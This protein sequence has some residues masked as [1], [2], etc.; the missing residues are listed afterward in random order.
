MAA[1]LAALLAGCGEDEREARERRAEELGDSDTDT[2]VT[3]ERRG[4][5]MERDRQG[6]PSDASGAHA[7]RGRAG[8][9]QPGRYSLAIPTGDEQTSALLVEKNMPERVVVGEV[10]DYTIEVTNLTDQPLANV[11]VIETAGQGLAF[12]SAEQAG[13]AGSAPG[14]TPPVQRPTPPGQQ[15]GQSPAQPGQSFGQPPAQF[16]SR[17]ES[18]Y[19]QRWEISQLEPGQTATIRVWAVPRQL[20]ETTT[21]LTAGYE[22]TIVARLQVLAPGQELVQDPQGQQQQPPVVRRN[23]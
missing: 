7:R 1:L 10:T 4:Y 15:P 18:P 14:R 5:G 2:L 11:W 17:M 21:S 3:T 16:E 22:P 12:M 6:V 23:R 9:G 19:E 13:T 20:G 8:A